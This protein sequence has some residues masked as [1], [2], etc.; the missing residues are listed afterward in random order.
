[1][2]Q[3]PNVTCKSGT[4]V[5]GKPGKWTHVWFIEGPRAGL[6]S[7]DVCADGS[8][9]SRSLTP[10]GIVATV[11]PTKTSKLSDA[12]FAIVDGILRSESFRTCPTC[13]CGSTTATTR[14]AYNETRT[15]PLSQGYDATGCV[16]GSS[17]SDLGR[18]YAVVKAY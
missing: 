8:C 3:G 10:D 9:T 14:V 16:D 5:F 17:V 7:P 13:G 1:M 2:E 11:N 4:C 18:L 12:D 6:S 15:P